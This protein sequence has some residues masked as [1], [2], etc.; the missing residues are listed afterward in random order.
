[1]KHSRVARIPSNL[2]AALEFLL[3]PMLVAAL[4]WRLGARLARVF[5]RL[6]WLYGDVVRGCVAQARAMGFV[7]D[8]DARAFARHNR[9]LRLID[10]A[11]LWV[12]R[13]WGEHHRRHHLTREGAWP[14][15]TGPVIAVTFHWG[16]GLWGIRDLRATGRRIACLSTRFTPAHVGHVS[17]TFRYGWVRLGE[18]ERIAGAPLIYA[19]TAAR[20]L[21]KTIHHGDSVLA[22]LDVPPDDVGG[23]H[24]V[25]LLDRD[26]ILPSGLIKLA[27]RT[28]VPVVFFAC[29]VDP[30]SYRR[31]LR[32]SPAFVV[33][34]QRQAMQ[35]AADA[36]DALIRECPAAWMFW[37]LAP[38]FFT[39]GA[40]APEPP[41]D[42]SG[43]V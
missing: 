12:S 4:P 27:R 30:V 14:E 8:D 17:V 19:A 31:R 43:V 6:P 35:R 10:H 29:D 32:V 1:M 25:R 15:G 5:A 33:D 20:P 39:P 3:L 7:D 36:L 2:R 37:P 41:E 28:G 26:A 11:D 21:L 34:D 38:A 13:W 42:D 23:R 24:P 9:W 22:L 18:V 16:T 40:P